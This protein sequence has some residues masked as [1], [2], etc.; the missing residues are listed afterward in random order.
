MFG[1]GDQEPLYLLI[2]QAFTGML[3][4]MAVE[5]AVSVRLLM[6]RLQLFLLRAFVTADDVRLET[7]MC[8]FEV[9]GGA[10]TGRLA[11]VDACFCRHRLNQ[12][13]S[14]RILG[15]LR[16]D[17]EMSVGTRYLMCRGMSAW[18]RVWTRSGWLP[19]LFV[20]WSWHMVLCPA[21]D[22]CMS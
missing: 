21:Q 18:V 8:L 14:P 10:P 17:L 3:D 13:Y 4:W 19:S 2:L 16:V 6:A 7:M 1:L 22:G 9:V 11:G 15:L 5:L 12:A 20:T